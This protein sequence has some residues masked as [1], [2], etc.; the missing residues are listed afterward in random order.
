M[1]SPFYYNPDGSRTY[2]VGIVLDRDGQPKLASL[3]PQTGRAGRGV[4]VPGA[5]MGGA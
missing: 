4:R 2:L 1:A 3:Q 5:V